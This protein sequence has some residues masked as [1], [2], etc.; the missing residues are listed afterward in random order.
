MRDPFHD[1]DLLSVALGMTQVA[2][3]AGSALGSLAVLQLGLQALARR[4]RAVP[5]RLAVIEAAAE[6][7]AAPGS[8]RRCRLLPLHRL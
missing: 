8:V 7:L 1:I 5:L 4:R 2:S 3:D 6:V